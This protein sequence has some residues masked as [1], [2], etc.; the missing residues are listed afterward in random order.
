MCISLVLSDYN[1]KHKWLQMQALLFFLLSICLSHT[2][3]LILQTFTSIMINDKVENTQKNKTNWNVHGRR[4]I[5]SSITTFAHS[6]SPTE[7]LC[8]VLLENNAT[9]TLACMWVFPYPAL[10]A[11][12]PTPRFSQFLVIAFRA[13]AIKILT[14]FWLLLC[15]N[16][17]SV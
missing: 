7:P 12:T 11:H 13:A 2:K 15:T 6:F 10:T 3:S 17:S 8:P 16:P 4:Y 14:K 9:S 5:S 1:D